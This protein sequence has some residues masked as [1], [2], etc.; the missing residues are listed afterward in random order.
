MKIVFIASLLAMFCN[1]TVAADF[2]GMKPKILRE[3][4]IETRARSIED[5]EAGNDQVIKILLGTEDTAGQFT[6]FSDVFPTAEGEVAA[7]SHEWH[8]EAFYVIRGKYEVQNGDLEKQIVG[9][10]TVVFSP[11]GSLH[12]WKSLEADSKMLVVYTPGGWEHF[13]EAVINLTPEQKEDK[14]FMKQFMKSYDEIFR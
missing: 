7:H 14:K 3:A 4:D 10:N 13:Y 12:A 2:M 11:R 8:D 9:P 1:I 6:M 5:V